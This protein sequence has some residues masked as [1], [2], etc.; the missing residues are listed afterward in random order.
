[1]KAEL[2]KLSVDE[3]AWTAYLADRQSRR[4]Q[5]QLV[6]QFISIDGVGQIR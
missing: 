4:K 2:L 5:E 3:A 6:P 1:M